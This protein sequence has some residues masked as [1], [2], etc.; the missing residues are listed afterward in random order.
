MS[1]TARYDLVAEFY[2][3]D[4][5]GGVDDPATARLLELCG[6]VAGL[7]LLD[8][9]CGQGRVARELAR[10]GASVTGADLSAEL[11]TRARAAENADPLGI[12]YLVA[13]A[14]DDELFSPATFD[15]VTCNY[16]IS[17]IDDLDGALRTVRRACKPGG[18]FVMSLLHPCFPGWTENVSGSWPPGGGYFAEGWWRPQAARSR[19]RRQV[20]ANHRMI[21]TYLNA[22]T[23]HDLVVS[24]VREPPAPAGWLAE[25]P[26]MDAVPTF[27]VV[28]SVRADIRSEQWLIAR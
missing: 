2:V 11:I 7:R 4:M 27:L 16:G 24:A 12:T 10:R 19:L 1:L 20:G 25:R 23:G 5:G 9:A 22:L 18:F 6:D 8:L 26:D 17:D 14:G 15:G 21:S 13:D 28:R 3:R